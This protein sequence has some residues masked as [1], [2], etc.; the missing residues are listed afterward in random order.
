VDKSIEISPDQ[1]AFL[2]DLS[3][4]HYRHQSRI[5]ARQSGT[6]GV[7][8]RCHNPGV[9]APAGVRLNRR[10]QVGNARD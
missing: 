9:T 6:C 1:T 7:I 10:N 2:S 5:V 3:T 8:C 4:S